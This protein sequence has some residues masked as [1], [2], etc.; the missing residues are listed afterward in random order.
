VQTSSNG[1]A[2]GGSM[3]SQTGSGSGSGFSITH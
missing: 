3:A 2:F 1:H